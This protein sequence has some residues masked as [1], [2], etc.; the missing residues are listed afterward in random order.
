MTPE[1][2]KAYQQA[3]HQNLPKS[4]RAIKYFMSAVSAATTGIGLYAVLQAS[5]QQLAA[6]IPDQIP[7]WIVEWFPWVMAFVMTLMIQA[8]VLEMWERVF[9][10]RPLGPHVRLLALTMACGATLASI[11]FAS[12]SYRVFNDA[13]G[14]AAYMN[15]EALQASNR[16]QDVVQNLTNIF[17]RVAMRS[18]ELA[19]AERKIGG[20]C[21]GTRPMRKCG[22]RCRLRARIAREAEAYRNRITA[23]AGNIGTLVRQMKDQGFSRETIQ[24][25]NETLANLRLKSVL[26]EARTWAAS[27]Q[28]RFAGR[29]AFIDPQS[30]MRFQCR[31]R[32]FAADLAAL[33][34]SLAAMQQEIANANF[35]SPQSA[36]LYPAVL[37]IIE[38][39]WEAL[40]SLDMTRMPGQFWVAAAVDVSIIFLIFILR[41][42][43][44][45]PR[46]GEYFRFRNY[47]QIRPF[48]LKGTEETFLLVPADGHEGA[49]RLVENMALLLRLKQ[50]PELSLP[51]PLEE[52]DAALAQQLHRLSGA[53]TYYFYALPP[54][55]QRLLERYLRRLA[56]GDEIYAPPSLP[57]RDH[58]KNQMLSLPAPETDDT[59]RLRNV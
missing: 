35:V 33:E 7:S 15:Q 16:I 32:K 59:S 51:I 2:E 45:A 54:R 46:P 25:A 23:L 8:L 12:G 26:P 36:P 3:K 13:S 27:Q 53:T 30:G 48:I 31:D 56:L 41:A 14:I 29:E 1:T 18:R 57:N 6:I 52:M 49:T 10:W 42:E 21:E 22:V 44:D 11:L 9:S 47:R 50:P 37:Q 39:A 5:T 17:S 40:T 4:L 28:I 19:E 38:L 34:K 20:T 55:K 58:E 43:W 24:R